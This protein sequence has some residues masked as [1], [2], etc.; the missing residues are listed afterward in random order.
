MEQCKR[1]E[2]RGQSW[3]GDPPRCGFVDG[4]FTT[5]NWN[6][7][8]LNTLREL[9]ENRDEVGISMCHEDHS[10]AVLPAAETDEYGDWYLLSWYK[11]RGRTEHALS[12]EG[13]VAVPLRLSQAEALLDETEM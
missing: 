12:W 8:T 10:V 11:S 9:I 3:E 5:D 6:C 4:V 7:A 2:K 13:Q 1:C